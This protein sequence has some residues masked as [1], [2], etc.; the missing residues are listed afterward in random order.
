VLI[1]GLHPSVVF[2]SQLATSEKYGSYIYSAGNQRRLLIHPAGRLS[3]KLQGEQ[4]FITAFISTKY[5]I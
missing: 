3:V 1:W 2:W 5:L 4:C